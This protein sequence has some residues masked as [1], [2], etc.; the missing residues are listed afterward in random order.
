MHFVGKNSIDLFSTVVIIQSQGPAINGILLLI[1][2]KC[3][4][5]QS[6]KSCYGFDNI[7]CAIINRY[8]VK[9]N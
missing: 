2:A 8:C 4:K 1:C 5:P 6:H 9:F 7:I 3:N